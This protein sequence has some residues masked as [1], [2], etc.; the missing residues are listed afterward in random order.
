MPAG[1]EADGEQ[2]VAA[3]VTAVAGQIAAAGGGAQ[4]QGAVTGAVQRGVGY[5]LVEGGGVGGGEGAGLG[6]VPGRL[7]AGEGVSGRGD[8]GGGV[9]GRPVAGGVSAPGS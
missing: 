6:A 9:S 5:Q 1:P 8:S 7:G 3:D 2:R 4:G